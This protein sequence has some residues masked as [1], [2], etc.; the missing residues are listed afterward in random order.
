MT[1]N[2]IVRWVYLF[3]SRIYDLLLALL[4]QNL[5]QINLCYIIVCFRAL[6]EAFWA[7]DVTLELRSLSSF[8]P[9]LSAS[10]N[11]IFFERFLLSVSMK[12]Q[13]EM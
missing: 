5:H 8:S 3:S 10:V 11:T 12:R 9:F 7:S 2:L 13:Q 4:F 6:K 1:E